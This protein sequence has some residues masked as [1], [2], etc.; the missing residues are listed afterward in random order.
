MLDPHR[1]LYSVVK[2][3]WS[4]LGVSGLL[5]GVDP[6]KHVG[7]AALTHGAVVYGVVTSVDGL[8]SFVSD[9]ASVASEFNAFDKVLAGIGSSPAVSRAAAEVYDVFA[10]NR[11]EAVMVDENGSN[12]AKIPGLWMDGEKL[13]PHV[14]AA[15]VIALRAGSPRYISATSARY[16]ALYAS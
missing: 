2:L 5:V 12:S 13:N 7:L 15:L 3:A 11:L 9:I 1:P 14:R 6:G 4:V 8:R 10:S 16:A